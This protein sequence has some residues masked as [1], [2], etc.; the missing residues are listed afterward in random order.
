MRISKDQCLTDIESNPTK[1]ASKNE[2]LYF[3]YV[4]A[5]DTH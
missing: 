4:I 1:S 3:N 2:Q 5:F